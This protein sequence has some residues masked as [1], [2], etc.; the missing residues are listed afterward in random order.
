M[1]ASVPAFKRLET[2]YISVAI[3]LRGREESE[4]RNQIDRFI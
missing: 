2:L 1:E 4:A 3:R